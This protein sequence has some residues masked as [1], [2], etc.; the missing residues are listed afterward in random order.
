MYGMKERIATIE[1]ML[2]RMCENGDIDSEQ[3]AIYERRLVNLAVDASTP[4][5]HHQ[6]YTH[7]VLVRAVFNG[8]GDEVIRHA[9]E[10]NWEEALVPVDPEPERAPA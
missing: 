8:C 9:L 4:S 2:K 10:Y 5:R 7:E 6:F 3:A 1:R